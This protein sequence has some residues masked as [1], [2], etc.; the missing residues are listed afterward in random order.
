LIK[1][2]KYIKHLPIIYIWL[3]AFVFFADAANL[4]DF[5]ANVTIIHTD[6]PTENVSEGEFEAD[7]TPVCDLTY[8]AIP[9]NSHY[10]NAPK[11]F[12]D[13][14]SPSIAPDSESLTEH[15]SENNSDKKI[16]LISVSSYKT[17]YIEYH[18]LLI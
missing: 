4:D 15:K 2:G 5:I 18:S 17:L 7:I 3:L 16:I 10:L 14:D 11:I 9:D 1:F 8:S 6:E 12:F 13:Q